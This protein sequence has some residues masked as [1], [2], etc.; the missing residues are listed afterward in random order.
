MAA[1]AEAGQK[2]HKY[3][4]QMATN[5]GGQKNRESTKEKNANK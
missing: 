4:K 1:N 3:M 5:V 2:N